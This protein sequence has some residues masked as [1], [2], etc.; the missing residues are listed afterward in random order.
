LDFRPEREGDYAAIGRL[1]EAA[2]GR[3]LEARLVERIRASGEN[4]PELALVAEDCGEIVGHVMFSYSTL[5][6]DGGEWRVLQLSPLTVMPARQNEGIGGALIRAG[7]ELCE[8]RGEPLVVLLGH[9]EY[10]P[11]FGFEPAAEHG[12]EPPHPAQ[13]AAFMVARLSNY[14][15]RCRGRVAFSA[16][17]D[18]T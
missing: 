9:P 7:L 3:A 14:D 17:F 4:V 5:R 12:I 6:G 2:F 13:A 8:A 1:V 18:G 15:A 11:R 16:A 10:Y